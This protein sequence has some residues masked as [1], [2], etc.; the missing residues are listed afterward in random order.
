MK[1]VYGIFIIMLV[2]ALQPVMSQ[3]YVLTSVA[4]SGATSLNLEYN[5]WVF[6]AAADQTEVNVTTNLNFTTTS[7]SK[8]CEVSVS[9]KVM[10]VSVSANDLGEEREAEILVSAKDGQTKTFSVR[11]LGS[12]PALGVVEH[13]VNLNGACKFCLDVVST[14]VPVFKLPDWIKMEGPEAVAGKVTYR[15]YAEAPAA[16]DGTV[17]TG[18][19]VVSGTGVAATTV[20]VNQTKNEVIDSVT[21]WSAKWIQA[22]ANANAVNTWQIYRKKIK[23]NVVPQKVIAKISVDS[24]YW[25]WINGK[26]V[27]FEG[28]LKRGPSPKD[29]YYDEVDLAPYLVADTNTIAVLTLF[30]GKNGFSHKSSGHA[31]FL[32]EAR[33]GDKVITSDASW[34]AAVYGAYGTT[35]SPTP[36]YR[37]S[38]SNIRFDGRKDLGQ[39]FAPDYARHFPAAVVYNYKAENTVFGALVLRPIPAFKFSELKDYVKQSFDESTRILHCQLP[40]NAQVTPYLKVRAK[41]G[42]TIDMRTEDYVVGGENTVRGEYITRDSVQEYESL[43]WMN[44]NEM[45]YTIPEGV[46]VLD[47]K[48]RESGYDTEI[49]SDFNCN[50]SFFNELWKRSARTLYLNMRDTYSDC[51]D[52]ERA[53]WWGDVTNDIQE[54]FYTLSPSSWQII[55]KGIYEL[56]NWQRGN[57]VIYAPV[58]AGNWATELPVQM[59]MSVGWY[60][61][62]KQYYNSGDS[63][64]VAPIYDRLHK[65]LHEVW[66][67]DDNG[68]AISRAGGWSWADWGDHIDLDLLTAEW[69]Y[70]AIKAERDFAHQLNKETDVAELDK[71]MKMMED[72]FNKCYWK[73]TDYRSSTYTSSSS[74][75][76]A[77][78]LAVLCGLAGK[79]KYAALLKIF[80]NSFYAS[81]LLEMYVQQALFTM[82]EGSYA[83]QRAKSRYTKMLSYPEQTT[84]FEFWD[85]GGSI[86]HAWASGMTVIFGEFVCGV[87][88]TSPGFKTFEVKPDLAGLTEV[89][90]N[91]ETKYGFIR[92]SVKKVDSTTTVNL[93]VPEGT[94]A[95]VVL[96][97][98]ETVLGPGSHVVTS[99]N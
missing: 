44:G 67:I 46:E 77:Q 90:Q 55:N 19:I 43:G 32:F 35:S 15:F 68:F 97:S 83:L 91:I 26:M 60:G 62:H 1:R 30:Y 16:G 48:Y 89:S 57:G 34:E 3:N 84:V 70:L 75:D 61:F 24:K 2:F 18:D 8:W 86:N 39:W 45:Q 80:K 98:K 9:G 56:M 11:Q 49:V 78:A 92:V 65:Y 87:R 20:K 64:F 14:V 82:G 22:A 4:K 7:D 5:D 85:K 23:L 42:V 29:S 94:Q 59:L 12:N 79:D 51:P 71:M 58:P 95:T 73:G 13:E 10:K 38:E 53:Q 72:N 27:V 28:G 69:Y 47:V 63:S 33:V 50:D 66:S 88:P 6:G 74:D 96:G 25:L 76:R 37:L 17:R 40:Y 52:R 36:N 93:T 41:A 31:A 54:N 99:A 81:P 21:T